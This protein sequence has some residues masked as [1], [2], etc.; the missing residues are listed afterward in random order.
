[1]IHDSFIVETPAG[2][3]RVVEAVVR[4]I[5]ARKKAEQALEVERQRT[6]ARLEEVV[7]LRSHL[8][9]QSNEALQRSETRLHLAMGS[10]HAGSWEWDLR[11]NENFWSNEVWRLYG[12]KPRRG[13]ASFEIWRQTMHPDDRAKAAA[14]ARSAAARGVE[15]NVE[16]RI[17]RPASR[18]RAEDRWLMARGQ[19]V[20]DAAGRV[21]RYIGIVMDITERK[22]AEETLRQSE[23]Q[24]RDLF[25][26]APVGYQEMDMRGRLTRVNR[27]EREMLGCTAKEMLGRPIWEFVAEKEE[28]RR[29]VRDKLAGNQSLVGVAFRRSYRRKDGA[30]LPVLIEDRYVRDAAGKVTGL[31]S[32]VQDIT[33][34]VEAG[35][36]LRR[37]MDE[38]KRS[39][40]DLEQFAYVASH[41]LQEPLRMV[42]SFTQLLAE[43]YRGKLDKDADEFIGFAVDGSRRM[44]SLIADLLAYSRVGTRALQPLARTDS[45]AALAEALA[46]LK[47]TIRESGATV[48]HGRL[49]KV[50]ADRTQLAQLFQNLIGNAVKFRRKAAPRVH[51]SARKREDG[52]RFA[53]RDNG[54]GIARQYHERIFEIFQRL[55]TRKKYPGTGI[56]LAICKRIVE[57]LGGRIWVESKPNKGSTFY[58]QLPA[59]GGEAQ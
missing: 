8:L 3:E 50:M 4:D 27:T 28:S 54:I 16:W 20:R 13:P 43:R 5:T 53:V 1:V 30:L 22:R 57:R 58:F 18:G 42:S 31:R 33:A 37:A 7:A 11:T 51:V 44:Q 49:P 46:G 14:I 36:K 15:L 10:A 25:E 35:N 12:L 34:L 40:A 9:E 55:H 47:A 26:D 52:W 41:D 32:T 23:R 24:F 45:K 39:N 2:G 21:R 56:G 48:T 19:P 38:L 29:T 59:K 17:R 6:Q